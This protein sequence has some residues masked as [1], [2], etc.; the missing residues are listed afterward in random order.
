MV[1]ENGDLCLI[2]VNNAVPHERA[3]ELDRTDSR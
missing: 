1:M 2:Q 3:D